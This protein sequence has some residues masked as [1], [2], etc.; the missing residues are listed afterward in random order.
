MLLDSSGLWGFYETEYLHSHWGADFRVFTHLRHERRLAFVYNIP[1]R[2][3][4]GLLPPRFVDER[5]TAFCWGDAGSIKKGDTDEHE[6]AEMV[7]IRLRQM[8]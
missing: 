3:Q 6:R 7:W 8:N 5:H 2:R 1:R 4:K